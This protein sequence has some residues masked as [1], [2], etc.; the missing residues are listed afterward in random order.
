M[1]SIPTFLVMAA[2]AAALGLAGGCRK[3][4]SS[5]PGGQAGAPARKA[6]YFCPMHPTY[7][8]DGPG[9]CPICNMKLVPVKDAAAPSTAAKAPPPAPAG[10]QYHCP[11]H[12]DYLFDEPGECG[13]CD[14]G[15]VP[16][17]D[18]GAAQAA[19]RV[20]G[21]TT[22]AISPAKQQT[23]GLKTGPVETHELTR[24]VRASAVVEHDETRYARIAPRFNGWVR[25]LE[26]NATGQNV[27]KGQPLFRVYSPD[28]FATENEYLLAWRQAQQAGPDTPTA[29]RESLQAL[30]AA[31]RRRLTLWQIGEEEIRDLERRGAA[32]DEMVFRA[33]FSGHVTAKAAVEGKA[34][35]MGET[36]YEVADLSHLWLRVAVAEADLPLIATGQ[37]AA[38][39]FPSLG[40]SFR[41]PVSFL[42]P[43]LDIQTRRAE[44]RVE[45][46]N[47]GHALRP[48]M[49]ANVE[50]EAPLGKR[51]AVP[52][53]AVI[54]TGPR[55]VAFVARPDDHL[56]PRE[57]KI[58]ARTD[59][60]WEVLEGLKPGEKVVT[61]ALFL[62]D[63]ESQLKAVIESMSGPAPHPHGGA[64]EAA[65]AP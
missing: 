5:G 32:S 42:Y 54:E 28:L 26:V 3:S 61:R 34:F 6:A 18:S 9:D 45:F 27:E 10:T 37:I 20:P 48:G 4:E 58:G 2:L 11:D 53:A 57:V 17:G 24:V 23:I 63:S 46:D 64:A 62:V 13:I 35:M 40:R 33:P 14:K 41:A 60:W 50:I 39:S 12:P 8:S 29:Q 49:W 1:K 59:D 44:A 38:V 15:L 55:A 19:A 65:P 43:H 21:R 47:P 7:T 25:A 51:L 31:A 56:E 22:V 36:L 16:V 30:L 52:A